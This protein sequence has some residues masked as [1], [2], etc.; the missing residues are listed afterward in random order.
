MS[1]FELAMV[2]FAKN[3]LIHNGGINLDENFPLHVLREAW[4]QA[5]LVLGV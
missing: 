3:D 1:A 5:R 2:R 4:A